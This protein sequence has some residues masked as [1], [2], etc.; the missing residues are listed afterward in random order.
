MKDLLYIMKRFSA[1]KTI[2]LGAVILTILGCAAE[3]NLP[4]IMAEVVNFGVLEQ[5]PEV[6]RHGGIRMLNTAVVMGL[7]GFG[8]FLACA[9][10]GE[11]VS[12]DLKEELYQKIIR[13]SLLQ[14]ESL[15]SGSLITRLVS[16]T[17][18]CAA[19]AEVVIQLLLEPVLLLVG[20]ILMM[21]RIS[22]AFD[23][24][25]LCFVVL[26]CILVFL[27]VRKTMPLFQLTQKKS[28]R[29]HSYLQTELHGLR[30]IKAYNEE[31]K[32][33]AAFH[34]LTEDIRG[35]ELRI[36]RWTALFNPLIMMVVNVAVACILQLSGW[37]VQAGTLRVGSVMAAVTYAE[38][39]LL[40]IVISGRLFSQLTQARICAG[41]IAQVLQMEPAIKGGDLALNQVDS[42]ELQNVTFCFFPGGAEVFSK[43]S[44][45]F[46]RGMFV[47]VCGCVGCGKTTLARL[48]N[49]VYDPVS[50]C[51]RINQEDARTYQL[52]H[53]R[54]QI[55]V[56]ERDM[57]MVEGTIIHNLVYGREDIS[58]EALQKAIDAAGVSAVMDRLPEGEEA[59][60]LSVPLSGGERQRL[61]LARA[62]VANPSVLV[63]DDCTSSLDFSTESKVLRSIRKCYPDIT[64]ILM[65]QRIFSVKAADL[66]ICIGRD[67]AI[68]TGTAEELKRSSP[69]FSS[70]YRSQEGSLC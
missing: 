33:E 56:V 41:R 16:D 26:Q 36:N 38:Q 62:L 48:L 63:L 54:R 39:V 64:I 25:F 68:E 58:Q 49:R 30:L 14:V 3:L 53:L 23:A 45:S 44:L 69:L 4:L 47:A 6:I 17:A 18:A 28:D 43:L 55:A 46:R 32:E 52:S 19:M 7:S 1:Q 29:L 2:L 65:T 35:T 15:G 59:H 11:R 31:E 50:G 24:V 20:G 9:T 42:L 67:G 57:D 37:R 34:I 66:V 13:L 5:N 21:W 40:S 12:R 22:H 51:I 70:L 27:F 60:A 61:A 8:S 10:A